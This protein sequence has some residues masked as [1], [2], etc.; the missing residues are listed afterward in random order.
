MVQKTSKRKNRPEVLTSL[1][2]ISYKSVDH[3][4]VCLANGCGASRGF[5]IAV[6][7]H[8]GSVSTPTFPIKLDTADKK[9]SFLLG[10]RNTSL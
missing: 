7:R 2:T 4:G 1:L 3:I 8:G 9:F 6:I 10:G 5:S